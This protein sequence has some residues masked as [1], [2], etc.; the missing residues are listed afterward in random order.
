MA[1]KL[2]RRKAKSGPITEARFST[3][4]ISIRVLVVLAGGLSNLCQV[5]D[6]L[7][8]ACSSD[9]SPPPVR[10][11]QRR[12]EATERAALITAYVSGAGVSELAGR[13]GVHRYTVSQILDRA[14]VKRRVSGLS[15]NHV[16]DAVRLYGQGWSLARIGSSFAV[17]AE[18]VRQRLLKRG[19]PMRDAHERKRKPT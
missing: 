11:R 16:T 5:L 1:L 14:G 4:P 15:P 12:L 8:N 19:V 7:A 9:I 6:G 10:Q 18:T 13:F 3:F 17:D 2:T